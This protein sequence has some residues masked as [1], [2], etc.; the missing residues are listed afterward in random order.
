MLIQ[1]FVYLLIPLKLDRHSTPDHQ[2]VAGAQRQPA[3]RPYERCTDHKHD[4]CQNREQ[5][6]EIHHTV[7]DWMATST[8]GGPTGPW[9][10]PALFYGHFA[11]RVRCR[12]STS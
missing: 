3:D 2:S 1:L 6:A 7:H 9:R 10:R 5:R 4:D 8:K 11:K 12:M